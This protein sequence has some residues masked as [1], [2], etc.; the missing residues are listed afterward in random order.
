MFSSC[1]F[2]SKVETVVSLRGIEMMTQVLRVWFY[3]ESVRCQCE[4]YIVLEQRHH[5]LIQNLLMF[6]K[7]IL[8]ECR[9]HSNRSF[10]GGRGLYSLLCKGEINGN[11]ETTCFCTEN[12]RH[13]FIRQLVSVVIYKIFLLKTVFQKTRILK[14]TVIVIAS[15]DGSFLSNLL[16]R[17][18]WKHQYFDYN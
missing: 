4:E 11:G 9:K 6:C 2:R 1:V 3:D 16:P 12:I 13:L 5:I 15:I 8:L 10:C 7:T 14:F 17:V 18:V